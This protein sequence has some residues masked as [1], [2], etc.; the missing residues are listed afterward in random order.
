MNIAGKAVY[1]AHE[2]DM[3]AR[4]TDF[5]MSEPGCRYLTDRMRILQS[6]SPPP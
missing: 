2:N 6:G 1:I 4:C 5:I 3:Y